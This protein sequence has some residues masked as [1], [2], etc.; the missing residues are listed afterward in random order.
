MCELERRWAMLRDPLDK[1]AADDL[2][3]SMVGNSKHYLTYT[4]ANLSPGAGIW[5]TWPDD[6]ALATPTAYM[7]YAADNF[8]EMADISNAFLNSKL[9]NPVY[10]QQQQQDGYDT[11]DPDKCCNLLKT[12][13]GL[14]QAPRETSN[15]LNTNLEHNGLMQSGCDQAVWYDGG[16]EPRYLLTDSGAE[17]RYLLANKTDYIECVGALMHIT[18][19]T[20]R[21]LSYAVSELARH[22]SNPCARHWELLKHVGFTDDHQA[23]L[24]TKALPEAKFTKINELIGVA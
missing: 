12:L 5:T 14:K 17:P 16:T 15:V 13:Y 19:V 24:F 3:M 4:K 18:A 2:N 20:Q 1:C 7:K 10:M 23:D 22:M 11:A 6:M 8:Y 21:I 9:D